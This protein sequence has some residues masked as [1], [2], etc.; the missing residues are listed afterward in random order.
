M[1]VRK[2]YLYICMYI[3]KISDFSLKLYFFIYFLY[4]VSIKVSL[5]QQYLIVVSKHVPYKIYWEGQMKYIHIATVA[6]YVPL[7][8]GGSRGKAGYKSDVSLK[9]GIQIVCTLWV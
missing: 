9:G 7:C 1:D 5:K 6:L 8:V 2:L 4:V 3:A